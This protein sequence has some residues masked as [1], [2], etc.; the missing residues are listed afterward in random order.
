VKRRLGLRAIAALLTVLMTVQAPS[1]A[2]AAS[3]GFGSP[4]G[5]AWSDL[6]APLHWLLAE[7]AYAGGSYGSYTSVP[8]VVFRPIDPGNPADVIAGMEPSRIVATVRHVNGVLRTARPHTRPPLPGHIPLDPRAMRSRAHQAA[9]RSPLRAIRSPLLGMRTPLQGGVNPPMR[10]AASP[11]LRSFQPMQPTAPQ[12]GT[13]SPLAQ[14]G[15]MRPA[16]MVHARFLH[17]VAFGARPNATSTPGCGWISWGVRAPMTSANRLSFGRRV[18]SA[19]ATASPCPSQSPSAA[20]STTPSPAPTGGCGWISWGV[21]AGAA[22]M[23]GARMTHAEFRPWVVAPTPTPSACPSATPSPTA[24]GV[25]SPTPTPFIPTPTPAPP[26]AT[27]SPTPTP[28]IP[29]PTPQPTATPQ[30][31]PTPV[32]TA[33][34][35]QGFAYDSH[36][37]TPREDETGI[38]PWWSYE[39]RAIPGVGSAMVNL[40]SGNLLIQATDI[41]VPE[42]G[43]DLAFRRTYNSQTGHDAK[44]TDNTTP[45]VYGNSWTNTFDAHLSADGKAGTMTVHDID[46]ATYV[47]TAGA[48]YWKAPTGE[49]ATLTPDRPVSAGSAY[50]ADCGYWWTKKTGTAYFFQTASA[51]L[52]PAVGNGAPF[53]GL[54]YQIDARNHN[55]HLTLAYDWGSGT[56]GNFET[57]SRIVVSHSDGQSLT[58]V[59]G[60]VKGPWA[61]NELKS[62]T[63]QPSGEQVTYSY[64]QHGNLLGVTRPGHDA[65]E[66]T[67]TVQERYGPVL[68]PNGYAYQVCNPRAVDSNLTDGD[69]A[70]FD[71]DVKGGDLIDWTDVGVINILPQDGTHTPLQPSGQ[72]A[73]S[74]YQAWFTFG[75][76][77]VGATLQCGK[78]SSPPAPSGSQTL[79][80][81]SQGHATLWALKGQNVVST[82]AYTAPAVGNALATHACWKNNLL[83]CSIDARGNQTDYAYDANGNTIEV[84]LPADRSGNRPLSTYSYDAFNNVVAYCDPVYN[85]NHGIVWSSGATSDALCSS[86]A[87]AAR[88]TYDTNTYASVEPYGVLTDMYTPCWSDASCTNSGNHVHITYSG[89]CVAGVSAF[90]GLPCAVDGQSYSQPDGTTRRPHQAFAYDERGD[91]VAYTTGQ[92]SAG[93][94]ANDGYGT[95]AMVYDTLNRLTERSDPDNGLNGERTT[96]YTLYN[97]DGTV[98]ETM[99]PYQYATNTGVTYAYDDDENV[100]SQTVYRGGSYT[101][102]GVPTTPAPATTTKFYDALDRLV[103]VEQPY[104]PATDT[105]SAYAGHWMTR[106][107]Y[108][109]SQNQQVSYAKTV[110]FA[111]HGGLYAT[112]EWLPSKTVVNWGGSVAPTPM[113]TS[114]FIWQDLT[115][116]AFDALGRPTAKYKMVYT[117]PNANTAPAEHLATETLTYDTN[118]NAGLLSSDCDQIGDCKRYQYENSRNLP[119]GITFKAGTG[120]APTFDRTMAYDADGR[121]LQ[122]S[123]PGPKLGETMVYDLDGRETSV[124]N[125]DGGAEN[126]KRL[127]YSYYPDGKRS[128]LSV[129]DLALS[130]GLRGIGPNALGSVTVAPNALSFASG[131]AQSVSVTQP[132]YA[133]AFTIDPGTCGGVVTIA[134]LTGMQFSVAPSTA[135]PGTTAR[136]KAYF[137]GGGGKRGKLTVRVAIPGPVTLSASHLKFTA[138]GAAAARSVTVAQ[139]N[140]AGAFSESDSC[141]GIASVASGSGGTVFTVTPLA[142]GTCSATFVGADGQSASLPIKVVLPGGVVVSPASL[143]FANTGSAN[144][145]TLT[146]TQSNYSGAFS[147]S[148]TCTSSGVASVSNG[149]DSAHFV[150]TPLAAGT[151]AITITGGNAQ[152]TSVPVT[153][154]AG[155]VVVTPSQ[156]AFTALGTGNAR[157]VTVTQ[158]NFTGSFT[159]ANDC[160]GVATVKAKS[161]TAGSAVY[162]IVPV[163]GGACTATFT[164]AE[165]LTGNVT[166]AVNVPGKVS[167]SPSSVSFSNTGPA[168]A[169]SVT[170]TQPGSTGPFAVSGCSGIVS[171]QL[172]SSAKGTATY[173]VTPTYSGPKTIVGCTITFTGGSGHK[174]TLNVSVTKAAK[175]GPFSFTYSYA[176]GGELAQQQFIMP[177]DPQVGT[178]NVDYTY[179]PAGRLVHRS[180]AVAGGTPMPVVEKYDGYARLQEEDFPD[181][182]ALT[183]LQYDPMG[184]LLGQVMVA[185]AQGS[186]T[187][188][189]TYDSLG[190]LIANDP[191]TPG[192]TSASVTYYANGVQ[193]LSTSR[194][195]RMT[196]AASF[197]SANWDA[198]TGAAISS[199]Y[200]YTQAIGKNTTSTVT[201]QTFASYDAVGRNVASTSQSVSSGSS[202]PSGSTVTRTYDVENH[203]VSAYGVGFPKAPPAP[204]SPQP[205]P[206]YATY[207]WGVNGHPMRVGSGPD[208]AT[209]T[210]GFDTVIWDGASPLYTTRHG[211]SADTLDDVKLGAMAELTPTDP[212]YTG[213]TFYDRGHDGGALFAHN[214]TGAQMLSVSNPWAVFEAN[215]WL[216]CGQWPYP[217]APGTHMPQ[218]AQWTAYS[219]AMCPSLTVPTIGN[220]ATIGMLRTD[221]FSDGVSTIQGIRAYDPTTAQWTS[222]DAYAGTVDDPG[223]QKSYMWNG[224]NPVSYSDPSGYYTFANG[225]PIEQQE[226]SAEAASLDRKVTEKLKQLNPNSAEFRQ[227]ETLRNDLQPGKGS[228]RVGFG[229]QQQGTLANTVLNIVG[230]G[231]ADVSFAHPPVDGTTF[232]LAQ[233]SRQPGQYQSAIAT[234]AGTYELA[235]GLDG[236]VLQG[237]A[238]SAGV[239]ALLTGDD[240][241]MDHMTNS[242]FTQPLKLPADI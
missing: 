145:A 122:V 85:E 142:A 227:L 44:N 201:A 239:N 68:T 86:G 12:R 153:V 106:Y 134:H 180:D 36:V 33:S 242:L 49:F 167:V 131:T 150:V 170:V 218:N 235:S 24:S 175:T 22:H 220:G 52:C 103:E 15:G 38:N 177:A 6:L 222:P 1:S 221:G 172:A 20:P 83:T 178:T 161:N 2:L 230:A 139:S 210:T 90:V 149:T 143:T 119:I 166:I 98:A 27:P 30:P 77:P 64:D 95:W 214:V 10:G 137:V 196:G 124:T 74:F 55:N 16:T 56:P 226:F 241:M 203:L 63:A 197:L 185:K 61:Y 4:S 42:R 118:G 191:G 237:K 45:D 193:V 11:M 58:L 206:I 204:P 70:R 104:N 164:G 162:K 75:A 129:P 71:I 13:A 232:D 211:A 65:A 157:N 234:E 195:L 91:L 141:A 169:Q 125:D 41:D 128:Q 82:Y 47:Y 101:V 205:H 88:F 19:V 213:L 60:N 9:G 14:R 212:G 207:A 158:R 97:P 229:G 135:S 156:V 46:G 89:S 160:A 165:G 217:L 224:N 146:V 121:P 171:V 50:S 120:T 132:N 111:A 202:L 8:P 189:W 117:A 147:E 39:Q 59:F 108:D 192:L 238:L 155:P 29:T 67:Q 144:A 105:T 69:C 80:C 87:G 40:F 79:W 43:I 31:T 17:V 190:E 35:D 54:L 126:G 51:A 32:T 184:E 181:G 240:R 115:A 110:S 148:D 215:S 116:T 199:S 176:G 231:T 127:L 84:A 183:Q 216:G 208:P 109:N 152:S 78:N 159:E 174:G 23:H 187:Q 194:A 179:T 7:V 154:T 48:G 130:A 94:P 151:C 236:A 66:P 26:T 107:L 182:N 223:S 57:L 163:S 3:G 136:C 200:Q 209:G 113:P 228:W 73:V 123:Q 219:G 99:T 140:Y 18:T 25:P 173:T 72:N 188:T 62:V 138:L 133:G 28:F 92:Q 186:L 225:T 168:Y 21:R 37:T 76:L 34:P 198:R 93:G 102:G 96:S 100:V 5:W 53:Q 114:G 81:D 112:Q 233:L